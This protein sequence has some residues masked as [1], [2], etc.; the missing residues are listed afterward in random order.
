MLNKCY[1]ENGFA[2]NL[3]ISS[4]LLSRDNLVSFCSAR[5]ANNSPYRQFSECASKIW[6]PLVDEQIDL[7]LKARIRATKSNSAKAVGGGAAA[8]AAVAGAAGGLTSAE[9]S[10]IDDIVAQL[11]EEQVEEIATELA[12]EQ[13]RMVNGNKSSAAV[14]QNSGKLISQVGGSGGGGNGIAPVQVHVQP[15]QSR[16]QTASSAQQQQQQQQNR[17]NNLAATVHL[18]SSSLTT[19]PPQYV[20]TTAQPAK[21]LPAGAVGGLAAINHSASNVVANIGHQNSL[22]V[23]AANH[24]KLVSNHVTTSSPVAAHLQVVKQSNLGELINKIEQQATNNNSKSSIT[25]IDL[26]NKNNLPNSNN[27][28]NNNLKVKFGDSANAVLSIA[29]AS[30]QPATK[31]P[32]LVATTKAPPSSVL[33]LISG[34]DKQMPAAQHQPTTPKQ[35]LEILIKQATTTSAPATKQTKIDIVTPTSVNSSQHVAPKNN[36]ATISIQPNSNKPILQ[37]SPTVMIGTTQAP[38]AAATVMTTTTTLVSNPF[39]NSAVSPATGKDVAVA[40]AAP[41]PPVAPLAQVEPIQTVPPAAIPSSQINL[42]VQSASSV[43]ALPSVAPTS[44]NLSKLVVLTTTTKPAQLIGTLDTVGTGGI[45][46]AIG[47]S[48][49]ASATSS[50]QTFPTVGFG[51]TATGTAASFSGAQQLVPTTMSPIESVI[52]APPLPA[53]IAA[54]GIKE[55]AQQQQVAASS[56]IAATNLPASSNP[57]PLGTQ[58]AI[59][60]AASTNNANQAA[61]SVQSSHQATMTA[62]NAASV[63]SS[64]TVNKPVLNSIEPAAIKNV[65]R[66]L[67]IMSKAGKSDGLTLVQSGASNS[68]TSTSM[69]MVTNSVSTSTTTTPKPS[70]GQGAIAIKIVDLNQFA[71]TTSTSV[72]PAIELNLVAGQNNMGGQEEVLVLSE[73]KTS[74]TKSTTTAPVTV[75]IE[76]KKEDSDNELFHLADKLGDADVHDV[77]VVG[78]HIEGDDIV[79]D[80][81]DHSEH[82]QSESAAADA[83]HDGLK[84]EH[85]VAMSAAADAA[86]AQATGTSASST[87]TAKATSSTG[88]GGGGNESGK[89]EHSDHEHLLAG[90]SV[91]DVIHVE[92]GEIEK[93]SR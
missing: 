46:G 44:S 33:H 7:I 29:P 63:A 3:A 11:H 84:L 88:S 49:G 41:V 70:A 58:S 76:S 37:V 56:N 10:L 90:L 12:S 83:H 40:T 73:K 2:M 81:E 72:R 54:G 80:Y 78:E 39:S 30:T 20:S 22:P 47:S 60:T 87:T 43:A 52:P 5:G 23:A 71:Q 17:V 16:P 50:A 1:N 28:N 4:N 82:H 53:T 86:T 34:L 31:A 36:V 45:P 62:N 19:V 93:A 92:A 59:G 15:Q 21:L 65:D 64:A 85:A 55:T 48:F 66:A 67:E 42:G 74:A 91:G 6:S 38:L 69:L 57:A 32:T 35:H 61:A 14:H 79:H 9:M 13:Q 26:T 68:S 51:S 24:T 27:N 8:A 75:K 18:V 25:I 77:I 89:D